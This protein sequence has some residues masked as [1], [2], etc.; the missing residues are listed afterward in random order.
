MSVARFNLAAT[1][2]TAPDGKK[3]AL[4]GGGRNRTDDS[5]VVDIFHCNDNG[6]FFTKSTTFNKGPGRR[7]LTATTVNC[8]GVD[9]A[10]FAGGQSFDEPI[11][12]IYND[13]DIFDSSILEF[14]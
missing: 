11:I 9:Y 8:G 3:Y 10:L 4:F 6:V 2:V 14:L 5:N 12:N 1:N 7:Y 13:I